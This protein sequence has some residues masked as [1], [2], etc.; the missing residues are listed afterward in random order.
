MDIVVVALLILAS[1]LFAMVEIAVV[2]S[3]RGRLQQSAD[4]GSRR[5]LAAIALL[6]SPN[7]LIS[8]TQIGMTLIAIGTGAYAEAALSERLQGAMETIPL[9][10]PHREWLALS[11]VV[12]TLTYF[13]LVLGELVPKR[14]GLNRPE[15]IATAAAIPMRTLSSIAAPAVWF[16][17]ASS[18]LVLR[19]LGGLDQTGREV[20]EEDIRGMVEEAAETGVVYKAEQEMVEGVFRLGDRKV[21]AMMVPR[22]EIEWLDATD[23]VDRVRVAV[24]TSFHSHY[25]VC[26]GGLDHVVGV[27]HVKDVVKNGL[28]S[29][30]IDLEAIAAPPM[31]V[32]ESTPAL[33]MLQTFKESGRHVALVVDEYGAL[34]GLVSLNDIVEGIIG[35]VT[36]PG[37]QPDPMVVQRADGSYL[38]DGSLPVDQLQDLMQTE[39]LPGGSAAS[40]GKDYHTLAGV[41][42]T[43]LG[44]IPRAGEAFDWEGFRFEIVDMD[45]QRVDKVLL[46]RIQ[47]P[48]PKPGE[49]A[50]KDPYE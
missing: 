3:R 30:A 37:S 40:E 13:T 23:S 29:D 31:F 15:T 35:E 5:A 20:T 46:S 50:G 38:L 17:S 27:V 48:D 25:P 12:L 7:R 33:R 44:H 6:D 24:A 19:L 22:T 10:A 9:L 41:V 16:I 21:K 18:D 32:P 43:F 1:G 4:R 28:V 45:G 34:E 11:V 36:R 14:I 8:T 39:R 47:N 26:R 2:S 42:V 49:P